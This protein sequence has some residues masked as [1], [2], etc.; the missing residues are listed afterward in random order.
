MK[1]KV[2]EELEEDEVM[3]ILEIDDLYMI[4]KALNE[5][6]P[7]KNINELERLLDP[8]WCRKADLL[9]WLYTDFPEEEEKNEDVDGST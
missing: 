7:N 4:R 1:K 2:C 9:C 3:L 5:Y 8:D 6:N